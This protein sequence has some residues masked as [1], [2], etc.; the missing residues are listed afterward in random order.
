MCGEKAGNYLRNAFY[1][2][3]QEKYGRW[4]PLID[5]LIAIIIVNYMMLH[6][7]KTLTYFIYDRLRKT[8]F[9]R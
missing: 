3:K 4:S 9:I 1:F 8:S 5:P 2:C 6:N 7:I